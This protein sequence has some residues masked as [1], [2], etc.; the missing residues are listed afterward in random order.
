MWWIQCERLDVCEREEG[1]E[2]MCCTPFFCCCMVSIGP[3]GCLVK[4]FNCITVVN[5]KPIDVIITFRNEWSKTC[6]RDVQ[7]LII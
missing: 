2:S 6:L 3:S 5:K 4:H 1:L 7:I